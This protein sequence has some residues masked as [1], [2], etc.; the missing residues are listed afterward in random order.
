MG[1]ANATV[2]DIKG[3]L[4]YFWWA[5]AKNLSA[6]T[7]CPACGSDKAQ[8]VHRKYLVTSL[9]E[10]DICHIRFRVP[11]ETSER[12]EKLYAKE[13]Y[14]QGVEIGRAHV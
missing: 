2:K 7:T 12:V 4:D 8:F 10:C 14:T 6:D 13:S 9:H 11:K 5:A 1:G 3:K